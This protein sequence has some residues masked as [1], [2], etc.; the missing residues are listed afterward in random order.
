MNLYVKVLKDNALYCY[1]RCNNVDLND[2]LSLS[3]LLSTSDRRCQGGSLEQVTKDQRF[4]A[5]K[6]LRIVLYI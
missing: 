4:V 5:K 2:P 1:L 6:S 3:R